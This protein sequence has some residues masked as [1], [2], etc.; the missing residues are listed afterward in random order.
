MGW[1][2]AKVCEESEGTFENCGGEGFACGIGTP[3]CCT[4]H[5]TPTAATQNIIAI[6]IEKSRVFIRF[7]K[8][9]KAF[10]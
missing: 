10:L 5:Q 7:V 2:G 9:R 8:K 6:A 3:G 1:F 4:R